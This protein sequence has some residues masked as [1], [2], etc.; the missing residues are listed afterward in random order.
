MHPSFTH[1]YS[2]WKHD[3]DEALALY[4]SAIPIV[5][6]RLTH[7]DADTTVGDINVKISIILQGRGELQSAMDHLLKAKDIFTNACN[8]VKME[9]EHQRVIMAEKLMEVTNGIANTFVEMGE[10]EEASKYHEDV[11]ELCKRY[12]PKDVF[13][14]SDALNNYANYLSICQND[15]DGALER[16]K[17]ALKLSFHAN[18][19]FLNAQSAPTLT[20]MGKL[21]MRRS[22]PFQGI[23]VQKDAKKAEVCFARAVQL[24][25]MSMIPNRNEKIAES[26]YNLMQARE[27]QSG[28]GKGILKNVRFDPQPIERQYTAADF[29]MAVEDGGGG[30]AD[31]DDYDEDEY[32]YD[33]TVM[34]DPGIFDFDIFGC[35]ST[36]MTI[37][38]N[39]DTKKNVIQNKPQL[40]KSNVVVTEQQQQ[41]STS[42]EK[43]QH[44]HSQETQPQSEIN[45]GAFQNKNQE[46]THPQK[47][48][49]QATKDDDNRPKNYDVDTKGTNHVV[50][51]EDF[52]K[53]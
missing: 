45:V 40:S 25:R 50:S 7:F 42:F 46:E 33:S 8:D 16:Y 20:N 52:L 44:E 22:E 1:L 43:D 14:L 36:N 19:G 38:S 23:Q 51:D 24:Y 34:T 47:P 3:F 35:F 10:K 28:K 49:L 26:L 15:H 2:F 32:T 21:Y 11:I 53:L 17:E 13:R 41:N 12:F 37:G 5:Q 48:N 27:W 4:L 9:K 39:D 30:G 31:D 18:H 29:L 6:E